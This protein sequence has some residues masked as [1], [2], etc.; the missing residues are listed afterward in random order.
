[1]FIYLCI[2][3]LR[4][5]FPLFLITAPGYP[6]DE[7]FFF[8]LWAF[9]RTINQGVLPSSSQT[10]YPWAGLDQFQVKMDGP[11]SCSGWDRDELKL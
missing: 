5:Y 9:G 2:Q 4:I 1:M 3:L 10:T 7:L 6:L 11:D 8:P